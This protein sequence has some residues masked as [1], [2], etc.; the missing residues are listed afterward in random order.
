MNGASIVGDVKT[1][2]I[3]I[4]DGAYFKGGIDILRPEA[5]RP[6]ARPPES[7]RPES[8]KAASAA[9]AAVSES[10]GGLSPFAVS[11]GECYPSIAMRF[12]SPGDGDSIHHPNPSTPARDTNE[13]MIVW[14][15]GL[16][17]SGKTTL[18][19]AVTELLRARGWQAEFLDGDVV[20][21]ELWRDLGF[22][23]ADREEN[24]RRLGFVAA[25]LA[26]NHVIAVVS[27]VSPYRSA[28]DQIRGHAEES[29]A[30][31]FIEVYVNAPLAVCEQRDV[32]G[33]YHRARAG[34][35]PGFTG[36]DDPYE[37]PLDPEVECRTGLESVEESVA[38]ILSSVQAGVTK[39]RRAPG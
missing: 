24:I 38:K 27:A 12:T 7:V 13:G 15:T 16:P 18:G 1:A 9:K 39:A 22:G 36:V 25:L 21:R 28:R 26:R 33:M 6:A 37:A 19:L 2:G 32:K 8:V 5:A 14:L 3:V 29:D 20:R 11:A 10:T 30:E 34:G 23:K 35:L 17:C 4:E 31:G